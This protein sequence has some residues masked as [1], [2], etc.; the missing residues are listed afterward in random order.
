MSSSALNWEQDA[1]IEA[2]LLRLL[3][4]FRTEDAATQ[5]YGPT[6]VISLLNALRGHLRDLDL[7]HLALRG[8]SLQGI[9]MQD[10]RLSEATLQDCVFTETINAVNAVAVSKDGQYWATASI[11]GEVWV[12]GEAGRTLY[13]VWQAHSTVG[14]ALAFS[15]NG[16][17]LASGSWD[18][19]IKLWNVASGSLLWSSWQTGSVNAVTFAPDGKSPRE[20]RGK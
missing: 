18:N 13:H 7:S 9:E 8:V 1:Q 3:S 4:Q 10:T 15:P 6:N 14:S 17:T 19:T 16:H 12:W 11:Q 20:W 2:H 5:G